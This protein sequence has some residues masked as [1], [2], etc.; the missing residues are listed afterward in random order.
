[1]NLLL[2]GIGGATGAVARYLIGAA[3]MKRNP[4]P[5][6]PVAML[7]VNMIGSFGLGLFFAVLYGQIPLASYDAPF[8]LLIGIGFFGA[9]TTFSTFSVEA[10][11]LVEMN[12]YKKAILYVSFSIVGSLVLFIVGFSFAMFW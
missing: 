12:L 11:Q 10:I 6:I 8:F 7:I 4:H 5:P 9:F 3:I 2:V 1:M